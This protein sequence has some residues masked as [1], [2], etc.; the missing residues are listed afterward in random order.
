MEAEALGRM[1]GIF[2]VPCWQE[3]NIRT[4]SQGQGWGKD[5]PSRERRPGSDAGGKT[6][7]EAALVCGLPHV[8]HL[9]ALS[10]TGI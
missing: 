2:G 4:P 7:L 1:H 8:G 10:E 3:G 6:R 9:V 5:P